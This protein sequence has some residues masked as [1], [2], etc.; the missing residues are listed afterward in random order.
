MNSSIREYL[1]NDVPVEKTVYGCNDL[2]DFQKVYKLSGK[3]AFVMHNGKR[4]G[5]K[6]YRVFASTNDSDTFLGKSKVEGATVE[7]FA[8]CPDHCFIENGDITTAKC[9]DYPL[10]KEWYV[11]EAKKRIREKFG[12]SVS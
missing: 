2:R 12:V 4:Y 3:Y 1:L 10:D 7:K 9:G 8:S 5:E 6:C 11:K